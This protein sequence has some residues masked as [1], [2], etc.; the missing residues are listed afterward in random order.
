MTDERK[1]RTNG[2]T[3]KPRPLRVLITRQSGEEEENA[4]SAPIKSIT[5]PTANLVTASSPASSIDSG[6]GGEVASPGIITNNNGNEFHL[7]GSPSS[8]S[9]FPSWATIP[10]AKRRIFN[11][12]NT[13]LSPVID[14]LA[15]PTAK[16]DS[17]NG[18][19]LKLQDPP[20]GKVAI[21]HNKIFPPKT[22]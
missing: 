11:F 7:F 20:S 4:G 5:V 9:G 8:P 3:P 18:T 16:T 6:V 21:L 10:K 1:Q 12:F 19:P 14:A 17:Q 15:L 2:E 13:E 22:N